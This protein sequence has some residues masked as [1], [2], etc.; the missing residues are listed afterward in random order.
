MCPG[1]M[2]QACLVESC[3]SSLDNFKFL[4][5]APASRSRAQIVSPRPYRLISLLDTALAVLC[6]DAEFPQLL[7]LETLHACVDSRRDAPPGYRGGAPSSGKVKADFS[8]LLPTF[9]A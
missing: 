1:R 7:N 5:S 8:T 9:P 4:L 2:W 3:S 6:V